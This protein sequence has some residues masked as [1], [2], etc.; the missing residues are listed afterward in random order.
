[1]AYFLQL[2]ARNR[3]YNP[4]GWCEEIHTVFKMASELNSFM[5]L[6][7]N[8]PWRESLCSLHSKPGCWRSQGVFSLHPKTWSS[9]LMSP[10]SG[11][12][13]CLWL[14]KSLF[15]SGFWLTCYWCAFW[16]TS[17][18]QG[19]QRQE[20]VQPT[21]AFSPNQMAS[22]KTNKQTSKS[23]YLLEWTEERKHRRKANVCWGD[24]KIQAGEKAQWIK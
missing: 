7:L 19:S 23:L 3:A 4:R 14:Q 6:S 8:P 21:S 13:H 22:R 16:P 15:S 11:S 24:L 18:H 12:R 10:P 1:M 5:L 2:W 9:V 20:D 17:H